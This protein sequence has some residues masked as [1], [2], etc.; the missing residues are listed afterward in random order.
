[1]T[2]E[3]E[4]FWEREFRAFQ[5]S[6]TRIENKIDKEIADLKSEQIADLKVQNVRLADDQRRSWEAIRK[7][8][9]HRNLS[10]GGK[11]TINYITTTLFASV[12]AT[13]AVIIGHF[14]H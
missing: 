12:G 5:E 13:I 1:M 7:L 11:A 6:L 10:Q 9:D 2:N 4:G 8:E 3:N 14:I